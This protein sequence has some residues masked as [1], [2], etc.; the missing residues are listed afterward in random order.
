MFRSQLFVL[1]AITAVG[2][3]GQ[4]HGQAYFTSLSELSNGGQVEQTDSRFPFSSAPENPLATPTLDEL[5]KRL[6]SL[7]ITSTQASK[8]LYC[9][10]VFNYIHSW[11]DSR[12]IRNGVILSNDFIHSQTDAFALRCQ[13]DF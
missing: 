8:E 13:L 11:A 1:V 2:F 12:P 4:A 10:C 6:E 3:C 9:K 5:A 7:E